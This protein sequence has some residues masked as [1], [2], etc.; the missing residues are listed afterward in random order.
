MTG[1]EDKDE[2]T[3]CFLYDIIFRD[4]PQRMRRLMLKANVRHDRLT[5]LLA[6]P[7]FTVDDLEYVRIARYTKGH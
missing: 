7:W 4:G 2:L 1:T 6:H 5:R 3:R